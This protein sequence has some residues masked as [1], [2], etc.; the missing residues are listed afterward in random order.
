MV[1][2]YS[3]DYRTQV[4]KEHFARIVLYEFGVMIHLVGLVHVNDKTL[5]EVSHVYDAVLDELAFVNHALLEYWQILFLAEK[6]IIKTSLHDSAC[7]GYSAILIDNV[8]KHGCYLDVLLVRIIR[9]VFA[10]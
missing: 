3:I 4:C 1:A 9:T 7:H 5:Q 8:V 2:A 6:E 10:W